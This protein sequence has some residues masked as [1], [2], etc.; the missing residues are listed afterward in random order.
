[1]AKIFG[2][3]TAT[4]VNLKKVKELENAGLTTL[5]TDEYAYAVCDENGNVAFA[6]SNEGEVDYK[7]KGSG[8]TT[9][10]GGTAINLYKC[11]LEVTRDCGN[12]KRI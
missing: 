12:Q 2:G 3:V 10:V 5:N 1:M 11:G 8:T 7:G 4:P 6:L 9:V